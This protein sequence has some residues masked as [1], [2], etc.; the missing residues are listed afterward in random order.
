MPSTPVTGRV[1]ASWNSAKASGVSSVMVQPAART[2]C[3]EEA[4]FSAHF[5]F[6]YSWVSLAQAL[7]ISTSASSSSASTASDA[8]RISGTMVCLSST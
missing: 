2:I 3:S 8:S 7:M 1:I 6:S 4:S 5:C